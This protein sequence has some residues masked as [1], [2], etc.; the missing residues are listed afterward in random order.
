MPRGQSR[1]AIVYGLTAKRPSAGD[2]EDEMFVAL[3][4]HED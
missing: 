1:A 2:C 3:T 4:N